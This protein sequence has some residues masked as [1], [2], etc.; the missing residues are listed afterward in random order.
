MFHFISITNDVH[1][2]L[3]RHVNGFGI[4]DEDSPAEAPPSPL[5]VHNA[6]SSDIGSDIEARDSRG[7]REDGGTGGGRLTAIE[8]KQQEQR[9]EGEVQSLDELRHV[10]LQAFEC[11]FRVSGG[12]VGI[13][14]GDGCR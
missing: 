1:R 14:K 9:V 10:Y 2:I 11:E 4:T 8:E 13:G 3:S 5:S 6:L 12:G 7:D